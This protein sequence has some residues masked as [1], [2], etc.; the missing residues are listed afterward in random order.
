MK[1][2][3]DEEPEVVRPGLEDPS[4][5]T[6]QQNHRSEDIWNG[7]V[8]VGAKP[9]DL[10]I[11]TALIYYREQLVRMQPN[12]VIDMVSLMCYLV[13]IIDKLAHAMINCLVCSFCFR[14]IGSIE[15]QIG[16]IPY[17]QDFGVSVNHESDLETFKH[18]PEDCCRTDSSDGEDNSLMNNHD[19][20]T[21]ISS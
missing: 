2:R 10:A 6:R 9:E 5:L 15:L 4:L 3:I 11:S 16:R 17:L 14:F 1:P 13:Q 19:R 21:A 20:S 12:Q 7:E 18:I 8:G